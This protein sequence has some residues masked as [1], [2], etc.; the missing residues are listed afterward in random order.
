MASSFGDTLR[1]LLPGPSSA[2]PPLSRQKLTHPYLPEGTKVWLVDMKD[3]PCLTGDS[4]VVVEDVGGVGV[5]VRR[6][7]SGE[8]LH[9]QRSNLATAS[10]DA[11]RLVEDILGMAA[12][13]ALTA[14]VSRR[15][16]GI[17]ECQRCW[18]TCAPEGVCRVPYPAKNV[19]FMGV[20]AGVQERWKYKCSAF[21]QVFLRDGPGPTFDIIAKGEPG[22]PGTQ[23]LE[24]EVYSELCFEGEHTLCMRNEYDA[25]RCVPIDACLFESDTLQEEIDSLIPRTTSLSIAQRRRASDLAY[26]FPDNTTKLDRFLPALKVLAVHGTLLQYRLDQKTVPELEDVRFTGCEIWGKMRLPGLKKFRIEWC[27]MEGNHMTNMLLHSKL[28]EEF[29]AQDCVVGRICLTSNSLHKIHMVRLRQ[30]VTVNVWAP[31][32]TEWKLLDCPGTGTEPCRLHFTSSHAL[33]SRLPQGYRPPELLMTT[34]STMSF[35]SEERLSKRP[36]VTFLLSDD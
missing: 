10:P 35:A 1:M 12:S 2:G 28:L 24:G 3:L 21:T 22:E 9:V 14:D 25:R 4:C 17:A 13:A 11:A 5:K 6:F 26:V 16:L 27:S 7:N 19:S 29:H 18:G 20:Y 34:D 15:I 23:G 33:R 31:Y 30:L 8:I 32:L 36:N